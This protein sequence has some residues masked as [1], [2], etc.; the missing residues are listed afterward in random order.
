[1][2]VSH[3]MQKQLWSPILAVVANMKPG[4]QDEDADIVYALGARIYFQA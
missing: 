2:L 3:T 4:L 1:M